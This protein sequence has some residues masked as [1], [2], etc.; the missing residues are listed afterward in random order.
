MPP[1][2]RRGADLERALHQAILDE[3]AAVG[4]DAA[5]V[6]GFAARAG[7][8]KPVLYRRWPTKFEMVLAAIAAASVESVAALA[9]DAGNLRADLFALL[10]GV[11]AIFAPD[12]RRTML[13]LLAAAGA[14]NA[15][16]IDRLLLTRASGLV[17]DIAARARTRGELGPGEL[18]ADVLTVPLDVARNDIVVRGTISDRRVS[19][20]IDDITIPLW[21]RH[22]HL[23]PGAR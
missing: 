10:N 13:G 7:T 4:Y 3:T 20:I 22:S 5:T 16:P 18:T 9:A 23:T 15:D 11:S 1:T 6:E 2:R 19:A 14:D 21:T 12:K 8:S 17:A